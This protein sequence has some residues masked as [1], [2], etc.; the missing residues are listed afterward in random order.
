MEM[1]A[2]AGARDEQASFSSSSNN[3]ESIDTTSDGKIS[4]PAQQTFISR[5]SGSSEICAEHEDDEICPDV[6]GVD[7]SIGDSGVLED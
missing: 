5:F 7:F 3:T 1:I 4:S 6:E 2:L